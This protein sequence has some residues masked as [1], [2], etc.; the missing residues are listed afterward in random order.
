M[1]SNPSMKLAVAMTLLRS[2]MMTSNSSSSPPLSDSEIQTFIDLLRFKLQ[3]SK[4]NSS[5]P[6]QSDAQRWKMKAKERKR[7]LLRLRE[8]VKELEDGTHYDIFPQSAS[9]KCYFFDNFGS[10]S[11]RRDDCG[12]RFNEVLRRRF[13]RQVRLKERRRRSGETVQR[14]RLSDLNTADEIELLTT[15]SDFLVELCKMI[16]PAETNPSFANLSHQSVDFILVISD[17]PFEASLKNSLAMKKSSEAIEGIVSSLITRLVGRMCTPLSRD[18]GDTE[19]PCTADA[20]FFVQH[21]IRKLGSDPYIGQRTMLV[22]S[23]RISLLADSLVFM[24]P[25]DDAFPDTHNFMFLLIQLIEFLISDH[26]QTWAG[27][28]GFDSGWLGLF[29]GWVRS[30]LRARKALDLLESRNGLY[31]LYMDR[32]VGEL[33]KQV[34]HVSSVRTVNTDIVENLFR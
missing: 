26:T 3:H 33:A 12:Q 27:S 24:D 11:P 6:S 28:E 22:V 21:L 17:F 2:K 1:E 16:N 18:V 25:F 9:C 5:S 32:V 31:V 34:S 10:L 29:E 14:R 30:V 19:S 20:Q 4:S 23:Q 8:E 13:L 7:E 15:S